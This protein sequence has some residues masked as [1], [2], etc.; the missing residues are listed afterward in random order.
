[1]I[2]SRTNQWSEKE[3]TNYEIQVY[4]LLLLI[5]IIQTYIQL[6]L[7]LLLNCPQI[8]LIVC[9]ISIGAPVEAA[10][11]IVNQTFVSILSGNFICICTGVFVHV[12]L[13]LAAERQFT[14]APV[15]LSM[16]I[17]I[18]LYSRCNTNLS[19][20]LRTSCAFIHKP[21]RL[22]ASPEAPRSTGTRSNG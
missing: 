2:E 21:M 18:L 17:L 16:I 19:A 13:A 12:G 3:H 10:L 9:L 7:F 4:L 22:S 11:E 8:C 6:F 5:C 1:S 15:Y 14:T 20:L